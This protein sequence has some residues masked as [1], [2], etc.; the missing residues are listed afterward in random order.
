MS[1]LY[2][3][4]CTLFSILNGVLCDEKPKNST[5][6][7]TA[8][9][10]G[11]CVKV[12][13]SEDSFYKIYCFEQI[14]NTTSLG[15]TTDRNDTLIYKGYGETSEC[16]EIQRSSNHTLTCLKLLS[17][18]CNEYKM[19]STFKSLDE[20]DQI[21]CN[22]TDTKTY[23]GIE[24]QNLNVIFRCV[25]FSNGVPDGEPHA[26]FCYNRPTIEQKLKLKKSNNFLSNL[27]K[28]FQKEQN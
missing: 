18:N 12:Y 27:M 14:N 6:H 8:T 15:L 24:Y 2:F 3:C 26:R 28:M 17:E 7:F 25:L 5:F 20:I 4:F 11:T 16:F 1:R 22:K 9:R 23:L 13:Y 21:M 10:E 19:N